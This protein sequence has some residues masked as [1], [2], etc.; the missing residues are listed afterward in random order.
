MDTFSFLSTLGEY[1]NFEQVKIPREIKTDING[2]I[3]S[4]I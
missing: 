4:L 1:F 2:I 3:I